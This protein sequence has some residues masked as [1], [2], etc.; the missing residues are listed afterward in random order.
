MISK[1]FFFNDM[2]S[3]K[4]SALWTHPLGVNHGYT[5]PPTRYNDIIYDKLIHC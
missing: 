2:D 4:G 3:H 1:F 5:T